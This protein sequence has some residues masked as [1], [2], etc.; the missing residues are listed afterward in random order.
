MKSS[1]P[2]SANTL[3]SFC[4]AIRSGLIRKNASS[5]RLISASV[6]GDAVAIAGQ[7]LQL[8][9]LA[10]QAAAQRIADP[11]GRLGARRHDH[12]RAI[13]DRGLV[14]QHRHRVR[15]I[16][17]AQRLLVQRQNVGL[18]SRADRRNQRVEI[19]AGYARGEFAVP[20]RHVEGRVLAAHETCGANAVFMPQRQ[21][22]Q[23]Q[24]PAFGVVGDDDEGQKVF[25]GSDLPLPGAE[26]IEPLIRRGE[27]LRSSRPRQIVSAW[28]RS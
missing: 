28:P 6:G 22:Q 2:G 24:R 25:A 4:S 5:S 23:Q 10:L 20:Q 1:T 27:M 18:G 8:A 7:R 14:R 3:G 13:V 15:Q 21:R 16:P 9:F 19:G 26:E 12:Q 11:R 17:P